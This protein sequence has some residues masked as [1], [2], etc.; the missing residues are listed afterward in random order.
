MQR[1]LRILIAWGVL[2]LASASPSAGA[3]PDTTPARPVP[4]APSIIDN[5]AR[6][7][8]NNLD[9]VVTNHGSFAYDLLTGGAGLIYPKGSTRTAVFAAGPWIGGKLAGIIQVAVGEYAQEFVPGPMLGGTFQPDQPA[10]KSYK[11]ERG[12]T[13]S[14]DYLNWPVSQGAPLGKDGKPLLLGDVT[15]WSVYN[16]ADPSQ[17][18]VQG[19]EPLGV[20][21]QQTTFAFNRSG[22]LGN[23]I[24][25]RFKLI[26]KGNFTIQDT[27]F[28]LWSDPD[29][30]GFTDD[31]VGYDMTLGMGYC[32]NATNS[33][34]VYGAMPP[35]VGYCL[36]GGPIRSAPCGS[37]TLGVTSFIKYINGT[38]PRTADE[39]YNYLQGLHADGTPFHVNDDPDQPFTTFLVS[40]DPVAGTGWLDSNPADRRLAVTTGPFLLQ[41]TEAKEIAFAILV[42]Q[43]TDRLSSISELRNTAGVAKEAYRALISVEPEGL[44]ATRVDYGAGGN[45]VSIAIGDLSGD[46]NPDLATANFGGS[47][48]AS[49]LLGHGDGTFDTKVDYEAGYAPVSI[50]VG[51]VNGDGKQDLVTADFIS[52]TVSLLLGVGDGTF[53][54]KLEYL[55]GGSPNSVAVGDVNGDE[56]PDLVT[57]NG[58][59]ATVSVLLGHGDGAFEAA[60]SYDV[61]SPGAYPNSVAIGDVSGD[62]NP[63]LVTANEVFNTV[64]VL[65]G[66][67][68][69]TFPTETEYGVGSAPRSIAIGD[70]SGDGRPDL[71]TANFGSNT[72]SVL[73]GNGDGTFGTNADYETGFSPVSV[74]IGDVSGDGKLDLVTANYFRDAVSVLPGNGDGTFQ[75]KTDY[76]TGGGPSSVAIGDLNADGKLDLATANTGCSTVSVLLNIGQTPTTLEAALDLDPNVINLKDHAPWVTA[77]IEPSGFEAASIDIT[78]LRLAGSVPPAPK[79]AVVGD[80]DRNG[81]PDLMV[82]FHREALDPLL[83]LGVNE[84]QVTGRLVTGEE[85]KG[86][87]RIRV[88]QPGQGPRPATISP[89]PLNPEGILTF[90]TVTAGRVSVKMFDLQ[91]GLVRILAEIPLLPAGEHELRFDGRGDGGKS[92]A[93]G[94]YFYRIET[95]AGLQTGRFV[96]LK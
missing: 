64:S 73:L 62:G 58:S 34:A 60:A 57:A 39:V 52:S 65:L 12:N 17:H 25:L 7:D 92:L 23:T 21:I 87:D 2:A 46:G 78:S 76:G 3:R 16:D 51:D 19:T 77:Y 81:K 83:T 11:I 75:A 37:D 72:V 63:D 71:V 91:G 90:R 32:Y 41:P 47:N 59:R 38:D 49:V 68:D 42:G 4:H 94:V 86:S 55:A 67:G 18:I 15:I 74:A 93:S 96:V 50:A 9:M 82:K 70:V 95:A 13:T 43:G 27:Y 56:K 33:D 6:M 44:F 85:F 10:F 28:S 22:P 40:G 5:T 89:N 54:P 24:F 80:H 88:I 36:L 1:Q 31:L 61:G 66:H 53:Q 84:L 14:P 26:N 45:P 69:G 29:L 20:E 8:A 35:A 79:F 48:T 30:G